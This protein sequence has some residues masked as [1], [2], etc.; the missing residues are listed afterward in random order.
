M[1]T[2]T[3]QLYEWSQYQPDRQMDFNGHFV[4][5]SANEPGVLI[6]PVPFQSGD[7]AQ[8]RSLGG[9][10]A[11]LLTNGDHVRD[12]ARCAEAFG[13]PVYVSLADLER[14]GLATAEAFE[15]GAMLPGGLRAIPVPD[16]KSPGETAFY[17]IASGTMIVGDA[18]IGAP[19]GQLSLLAADKYADVPRAARGLRALLSRR[20]TRLLLGDGCSILHE[21][22]P[23]IQELIYRLDP[24][25]FVVRQEELFWPPPFTHGNRFGGQHAEYSQLVGLKVIDFAM[26][27]LMPGRQ[28]FPLHRHDGEEELF[29][30]L[31]GRGEVRTEQHAFPIQAGDVLAFP[32]RFQLAHAIRNTG[33]EDL[34]FL[35]FAAPAETLEMVDYPDAGTRLEATKYG[36]RRRFTLPDRLDVPYFEGEQ[37]D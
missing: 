24:A 4:L 26:T 28:N 9:V 31:S 1:K 13:C 3:S 27:R 6:D 2:I 33:D 34:R 22:A 35:S 10:A 15:P 17:H 5:P 37:V 20:L 7:E 12:A 30:V 21:P 23:A 32:P 14:A 11:V 29:V 25:A 8:V 36:K 16:N 19:A 18:V